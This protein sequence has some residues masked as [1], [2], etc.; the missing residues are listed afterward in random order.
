MPAEL[1]RE[2]QPGDKNDR[3]DER[4]VAKKWLHYPNSGVDDYRCNS[5]LKHYVV[6][7][8]TFDDFGAF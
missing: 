2:G 3:R 7:E 4:C 5:G 6:C 1:W 8:R